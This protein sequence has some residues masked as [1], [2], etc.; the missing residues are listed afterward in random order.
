[1][2]N[3][4][5]ATG[6]TIEEAIS[7]ALEKLNAERKGVQ[8]E[9]LEEGNKGFFGIIGAKD[10]RVRVTLKQTAA[11]KA[12]AFLTNIFDKMGVF[13]NMDVEEEDNRVYV[14][15]EGKDSGVVIG[16]RGETLDAIQYLS[17]LA[18]N[19][20]TDE[21]KKVFIDVENYRQK[22]ENTLIKLSNRLA[23]RVFRTRR[24]ITLEP[25][26][27]YERRIIHAALQNDRNVRT[28]SV[29]DEP[30]R[31]VVIAPRQGF[32]SGDKKYKKR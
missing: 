24:N 6:K 4:V 2:D 5:E 19:N 8:V 22:R 28:Y 11:N 9:V 20:G 7:S 27:P 14:T 26:T 32:D 12:E 30:N 10:A 18:T 31:K 15:I 25:M 13:V 3:L 23:E 29:G 21:Y 17:C 16:R 1:M